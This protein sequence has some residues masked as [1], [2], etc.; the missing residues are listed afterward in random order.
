MC[1][2]YCMTVQEIHTE[3][4]MC[5]AMTSRTEDGLLH[6]ILRQGSNF[7]D[8]ECASDGGYTL[9]IKIAG[10]IHSAEDTNSKEMTRLWRRW[11]GI[12]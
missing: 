6:H 10:E 1:E 5:G 12:S 4:L 2:E 9:Q 7:A 3:I 8:L 11:C